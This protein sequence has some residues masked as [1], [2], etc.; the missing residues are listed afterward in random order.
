MKDKIKLLL[1]RLEK[2]NDFQLTSSENEEVVKES[3]LE[4]IDKYK[5]HL[6]MADVFKHKTLTEDKI[7]EYMPYIN[8]NHDLVPL[9]LM[10]KL[11]EKF[12]HDYKDVLPWSMLCVH[13]EMSLEFI[14]K[15]KNYID[16]S[17]LPFY[18]KNISKE[19][20][21]DRDVKWRLLSKNF[22][23]S[24]DFVLAYFELLDKDLLKQN[25]KIKIT[26]KIQLLLKLN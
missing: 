18:Q 26:P 1:K 11:S 22:P 19:M 15:H 12:M 20:V 5:D 2:E 9:I 4:T 8:G 13:Q 17:F 6:M 3:S 21:T 25:K 16:F 10:Q 14:N 24:E 7:R 23:L